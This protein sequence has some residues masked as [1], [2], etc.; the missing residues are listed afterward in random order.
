MKATKRILAFALC[1]LMAATMVARKTGSAPE[2]TEGKD[3]S[4]WSELSIYDN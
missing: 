2:T 1:V 4:E 3:Y